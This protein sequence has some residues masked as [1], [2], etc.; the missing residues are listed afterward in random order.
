MTPTGIDGVLD[1]R[2]WEREGSGSSETVGEGRV[3]TGP[4]ETQI[5][6]FVGFT[7][8]GPTGVRA[9]PKVGGDREEGGRRFSE[10]LSRHV[11]A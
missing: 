7:G 6:T 5:T 3:R 11:G 10:L 9:V 1:L 4:S 2:S 8:V